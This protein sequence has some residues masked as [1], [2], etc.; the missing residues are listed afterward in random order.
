MVQA[1][2]TGPALALANGKRLVNQSL[3]ATLSEQLQ[4]EMESFGECA[5]SADFAEGIAAFL[6]RR[7]PWFGADPNRGP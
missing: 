2:V 6:A 5:A 4:K 7:P 1:L 3:S